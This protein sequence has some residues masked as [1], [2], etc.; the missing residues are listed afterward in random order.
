VGQRLGRATHP[1]GGVAGH[2]RGVERDLTV[3]GGEGVPGEVGGAAELS[4]RDHG[5]GLSAGDAERVFEPFYRPAGR[6]EASGG[7]GLGLSL[8]RQIAAHHGASV[9][10]EAPGRG[11]LALRRALRQSITAASTRV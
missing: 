11:R 3:A 2:H 4:V 5:A 9:R 6:S 1:A 7:W 8:V 10:Y